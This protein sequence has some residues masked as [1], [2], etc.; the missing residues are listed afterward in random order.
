MAT[1]H[2][3]SS[4]K[5]NILIGLL[6]AFTMMLITACGSTGNDASKF[7]GTWIAYDKNNGVA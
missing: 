6:L 4:M 1:Q 7:E 3:E 2:K 5:R